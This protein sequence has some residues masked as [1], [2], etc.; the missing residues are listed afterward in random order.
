MG[1]EGTGQSGREGIGSS[2]VSGAEH[3]WVG[4]VLVVLLGCG[5]GSFTP[6]L[7]LISQSLYNSSTSVLEM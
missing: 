6:L 3:G 7:V 2:E 1:A 4:L 5:G